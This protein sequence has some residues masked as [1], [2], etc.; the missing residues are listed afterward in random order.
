MA[1]EILMS[2]SIRGA[3]FI[4]SNPERAAQILQKYLKDTDPELL[5]A[6]LKQLNE[7]KV[8]PVNGG[9]DNTVTEFTANLEYELRETKTLFKP[10][11]VTDSAAVN[12]ALAKVGRQP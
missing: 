3:R 8:W 1:F 4:Q 7:Q 2:A 12:A 9:L 10:E 11:Q 6:V 5:V